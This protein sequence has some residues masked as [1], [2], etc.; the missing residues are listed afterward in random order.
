MLGL[1]GTGIFGA[2]KLYGLQATFHDVSGRVLPMMRGMS[3]VSDNFRETRAL[4]LALLLEEDEDIRKGFAKRVADSV[5]RMRGGIEAMRQIPEAESLA[6]ALQGAADPYVAAV[7][8]TVKSADRKDAAQVLL[9]T[10]VM[11]AEKTLNGLL[12]TNSEQMQAR[13]KAMEADAEAETVRAATVF[14]MVVASSFVVLGLLGLFVYRSVMRPLNALEGALTRVA[15]D[16][17]FTTRVPV[18]HNDEIGKIVAAF[19]HL[20]ITV[21]ASLKEVSASTATLSKATTR[22]RDASREMERV[23]TQ[24]RDASISVNTSVTTVSDS[25]TQV[26][27]QTEQAER[28]AQE[29]GTRADRGGQTIRITID[30]IRNISEIVH[31]AATDINTL[32]G[33]V[34]SI[35]SVVGV[36]R[37]VADQ[38]NLLALNAAIEAARAGEAGRGFAVVADEVRKLA[39]RTAVSTGQISALIGEVQQ[40]TGVAVGTMQ[41][42][43]QQVEQGVDTASA[44]IDALGAISSSS[45]Q[46]SSI[47]SL[48]AGSVREQKMATELISEEFAGLARNSGEISEA[49]ALSTHGTQE[50]DVLAKRLYDTLRRYRIE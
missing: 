33:Q 35:S 6:H 46:V 30:Q 29:S 44:A 38:T 31:S 19:N 8:E 22:L 41:S 16:M 24:T 12:A 48:I 34:D 27:S 25:I 43:V 36:I 28:L 3:A 20:L 49:T 11:P 4:L 42:V 26:A 5:E 45:A 17:D 14:V 15:T 21:Q 39:E 1:V 9:Y 32:R 13:E 37:E 10:K 2:V 50:L 7:S 40:S 47:V 23:S 18:T